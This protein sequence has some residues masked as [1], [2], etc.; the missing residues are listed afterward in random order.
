MNI[1]VAV[2]AAPA[3]VMPGAAAIPSVADDRQDEI[4]ANLES[5]LRAID[6]RSQSVTDLTAEFVQLKHTPLLRK[7]LESKGVIKVRGERMRWDT[8]NPSPS[9]MTVNEN[10]MRIY[11]P[12]ESLMEVYPLDSQI[13]RIAA[14]PLPRL[15]DVRK[16]F[17]LAETPWT[18][19]AKAPRS[20]LS[21]RLVPREDSLR[22]HV[23]EVLVLIDEQTGCVVA[24]Q[25]LYPDH[26]RLELS[27]QNIKRN[28]GLDEDAVAL[29]VPPGTAVSYPIGGDEIDS[30]GHRKPVR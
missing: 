21:L 9:V 10:E 1:V 7:P 13:G 12:Q 11:F 5:R 15:D 23:L 3:F 16:Q 6:E 14:S 2:I 18:G 22:K 27:F 30:N 8:T 25:M 24:S 4:D 17:T 20:S 19:A 26:E 29:D 28:V